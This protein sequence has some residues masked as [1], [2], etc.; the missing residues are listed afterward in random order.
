MAHALGYTVSVLCSFL[1]NSYITC[2][3]RPTWRALI[4][5]PLSSIFNLV[6]SGALLYVAVSQLGMDRNVAALVAGVVVT[7]V[8]FVLARWAINSGRQPGSTK[9]A[10]GGVRR[11]R[12]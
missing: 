1:L 6:V 5:Y 4:R 10:A 7:P 12:S 2:R 11:I 9:V 3:T 8:S